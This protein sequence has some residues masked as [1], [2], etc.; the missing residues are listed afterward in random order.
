MNGPENDDLW[1]LLGKAKAPVASPFFARNVLR[2]IRTSP[3]RNVWQWL[4]LHWKL[5]ALATSLAALAVLAGISLFGNLS[6]ARQQARIDY[7]VIVDLEDL[8]ASQENS[9]WLETSS[10]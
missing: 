5:S 2:E 3:R 8:L 10:F 6:D 9:V 7:E 4:S 1:N